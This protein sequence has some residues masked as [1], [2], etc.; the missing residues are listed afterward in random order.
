MQDLSDVKNDQVY[1]DCTYVRDDVWRNG[2]DGG[3]EFGGQN[4]LWGRKGKKA[5]QQIA[6]SKI[7]NHCSK[8]EIQCKVNQNQAVTTNNNC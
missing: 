7:H 4:M 3:V 1:S 6:K 8:V 5:L 2:C